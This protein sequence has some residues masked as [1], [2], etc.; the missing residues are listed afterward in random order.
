MGAARGT[1]SERSM[2][3]ACTMHVIHSSKTSGKAPEGF[4]GLLFSH[5][6]DISEDMVNAVN[7]FYSLNPQGYTSSTK[8]LLSSFPRKKTLNQ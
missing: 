3:A 1:G 6:S 7:Q 8:L 4:I 5:C 2:H